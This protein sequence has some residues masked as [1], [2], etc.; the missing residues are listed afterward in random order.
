MRLTGVGKRYGRGGRWILRGVD[1]ALEP[2]A[3]VRIEGANGS[4]KSTLLK[5]AAVVERPSTGRV[6]GSGR[7][8]YLPER[9]SPALPFDA[10]GYLVALGRVH[11]L[12]A[13]RARQ[14]AEYWLERLG[15]AGQA[16]VPLSRLSK[17]T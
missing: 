7:R 11:G 15:L 8:A 3:L 17:G 10:R 14:R 1:L 5:L 12:P 16:G 6:E 2:G 9:F 13:A 4:G